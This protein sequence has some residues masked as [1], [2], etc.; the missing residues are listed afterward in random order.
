MDFTPSHDVSSL[1]DIAPA[2]TVK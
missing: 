2:Q 1:N